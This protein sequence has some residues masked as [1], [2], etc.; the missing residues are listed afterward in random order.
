MTEMPPERAA[1]VATGIAGLDRVLHGGLLAHGV[2]LLVGPSG[3]GKTTLANQIAFFQAATAPVTYVTVL[4]E[5]HTRLLGH[6]RQFGFF[7]P[8]LVS[9]RITY[10]SGYQAFLESGYGGLSALLQPLMLQQASGLLVVDGLPLITP[11]SAYDPSLKN[12]MHDLQTYSEFGRCTT[13]LLSPAHTGTW[14]SR[15]LMI[16]DG[17]LELTRTLVPGGIR[18]TLQI[19]VFRGAPHEPGIYPLVIDGSGIVVGE[20]AGELG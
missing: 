1:R 14:E 11:G 2:Y 12:L 18:R 15:A 13:L 4:A 17:A 3:A 7:D 5:T 10:L 6:I 8:A 20:A 16:V 9:K 19:Q